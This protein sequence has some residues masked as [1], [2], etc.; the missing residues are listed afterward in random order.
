[1]GVGLL[2]G[3]CRPLS[4][5]SLAVGSA[6]QFVAGATPLVLAP[7]AARAEV[8]PPNPAVRRHASRSFAAP[9]TH[10]V[11][12][13]A[14]LA[15]K[16]GHGFHVRVNVP[17]PG[18]QSG[19]EIIQSALAAR[20]PKKTVLG[21]SPQHSN[22]KAHSRQR[23]GS[24][25]RLFDEMVARV[26]VAIVL[27]DGRLSAR[28]AKHAERRLS[29]HPG[30]QHRVEELDIDAP[31]VTAH[32]LIEDID[33]KPAVRFRLHGPL[34]H[35]IAP[36]RWRSA[37]AVGT[38]DDREELIVARSQLVPEESIHGQRIFAVGGVDGTKHVEVYLVPLHQ[39]NRL[40]DPFERALAGFVPPVR[41]V[42]V[43]WSIQTNAN[44]EPISAQ[45]RAPLVIQQDAVG[46]NRMLDRDARLPV[47]LRRFRREAVKVE[48]HERGLTALP[49]NRDFGNRMGLDGLANVTL[50]H[51]GGHAEAAA[52]ILTIPSPERNSSPLPLKG[53]H[54]LRGDQSGCATPPVFDWSVATGCSHVPSAGCGGIESN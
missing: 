26:K 51:L 15:Q 16:G 17:E 32:P 19:A 6:D 18:L 47:T 54:Q 33:E 29:Q 4:W 13:R 11:A 43:A 30:R 49:G 36:R 24:V 52:W 50:H 5:T 2:H 42:H 27:H 39:A 31:K 7:A 35:L 25:S 22:R 38:F 23:R 41:A 12:R 1:M 21:A 48:A 3:M 28:L 44:Q 9:E 20:R 46:L 8:V 34:R 53:G 37:V 14:T 10:N 45:E 40:H